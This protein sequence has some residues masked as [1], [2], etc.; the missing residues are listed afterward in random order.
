MSTQI[1]RRKARKNYTPE[2]K[3]AILRRHLLEKVPI[4]QICQD[5]NLQPN[6]FYQWQLKFFENGAAAF[7]QDA[8]GQRRE[9]DA[10][11]KKIAALETKLQQKNEVVA[12][13]L[14]EH[15]QLKKELGEL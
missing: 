8:R 4:S 11:L 5:N 12:E 6:T 14:Q 7:R 15:V 13:L 3:I 1:S 9:E 2:E 10:N